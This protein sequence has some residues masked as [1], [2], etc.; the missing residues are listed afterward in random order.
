MLVSNQWTLASMHAESLLI[1]EEF[2][3]LSADTRS[4]V[5]ALLGAR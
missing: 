1:G 3:R 2:S 5:E 4:A